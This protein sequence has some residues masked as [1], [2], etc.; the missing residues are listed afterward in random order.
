MAYGIRLM[1]WGERACFTRPEMK[2]ERVSY[3]VITPSA[4]RGILEAIHWKPAIRWVVD[5]IQVLRP[6]RFESIRRNEVGGKLSAASVGKAMKAGRIDGLVSLVEEDRQQR[7]TTLL[8][9]VAYVI[10]AHFE[11]TDR[12]G[13]DDTVGKHLDIFNRR[14]RKGQCFHAPC[15]GVREFPASFRLLEEGGAEPAADT[16]LCGERDLGWMLHDIDFADGM[17]PH[18]FRALMRDG[19]IEVPAFRAAEVKA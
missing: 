2:V 11:L 1:V 12:A 13:A 14:A 6:I 7:A 9:D 15:L 17:T 10:E 3:D 19:L 8:R 16:S 4:A 18:F 5:R